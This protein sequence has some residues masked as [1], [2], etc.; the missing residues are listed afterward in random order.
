M[1]NDIINFSRDNSISGKTGI[2]DML[3]YARYSL[4]LSLSSTFT[5]GDF[6]LSSSFT[7]AENTYHTLSIKSMNQWIKSK[8]ERMKEKKRK[9][10][11][12]KKLSFH[13]NATFTR[14]SLSTYNQ[15]IFHFN[16]VIIHDQQQRNW[17]INF[18]L[19]PPLSLDFVFFL[20]LSISW[21]GYSV[22][23]KY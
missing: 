10:F 9:L 4:S 18:L 7:S 19:S 22:T 17:N 3:M 23:K 21:E 11:L 6:F 5:C 15:I 16:R 2:M 13:V 20:F 8:Q 12:R 1:L 14:L